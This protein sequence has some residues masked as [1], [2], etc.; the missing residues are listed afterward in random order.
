MLE[1][2]YWPPEG[3]PGHVLVLQLAAWQPRGPGHCSSVGWRPPRHRSLDSTVLCWGVAFVSRGRR[4]PPPRT[5]S[6]L[7]HFEFQRELKRM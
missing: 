4:G 3:P 6:S 2:R 7:V 1:N 5:A